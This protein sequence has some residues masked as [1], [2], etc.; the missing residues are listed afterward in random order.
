FK[1]MTPKLALAMVPLSLLGMVP[2]PPQ[3]TA[4]ERVNFAPGGTIRIDG[5]Y[6]DLNVDAWDRPEVEVTVIK[7]LSYGYKHKPPDQ[8][9]THLDGVRIVTERKSPMELTI[10]T[11]LPSRHSAWTP[12]FTHHTTGGVGVEY[13]IHVPRDSRLAI[14]HGTGNVTVNGVMGDIDATARRGDILLW[15]PPDSYSVDAKSK[16]GSVSSDLEGDALNQYLFGQRFTRVTP[17]PSHRLHL[18]MGF[19]GI[20]IKEILPETEMPAAPSAP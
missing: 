4:T 18:R 14:H 1:D 12:P 11:A 13:E 9:N 10:S 6:G 2:P 5:S 16:F 3:T 7:S 19:G 15:L 17:A 20:T 8:P